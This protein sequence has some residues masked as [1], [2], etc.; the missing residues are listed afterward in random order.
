MHACGPMFLS[1]RHMAGLLGESY[2]E[3]GNPPQHAHYSESG[4]VGGPAAWPGGCGGGMPP[5]QP[6]PEAIMCWYMAIML[7]SGGGMPGIGGPKAPGNGKN[8]PARHGAAGSSGTGPGSRARHRTHVSGTDAAGG[9]LPRCSKAC[10]AIRLSH[11][12]CAMKHAGQPLRA[13]MHACMHGHVPGGICGGICMGCCWPDGPGMPGP[14]SFSSLGA[15][16]SFASSRGTVSI[17][18]QAWR[19]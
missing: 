5:G 11:C 4:G 13:R 18:M 9:R 1:A 14:A 12:V 2:L 17:C 19:E 15:L 8:A 6:P 16:G 3:S 7:G 10:K